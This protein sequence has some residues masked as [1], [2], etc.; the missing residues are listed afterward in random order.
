MPSKIRKY[1]IKEMY[2]LLPQSDKKAF[3]RALSDELDITPQMIYN[4]MNYTHGMGSNATAH[5]LAAFAR[6]FDVA[7]EDLLVPA[8]TTTAA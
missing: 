1:R 4:I 5:Q 2:D 3:M 8:P 6:Y 7:M